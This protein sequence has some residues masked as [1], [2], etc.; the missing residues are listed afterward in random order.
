V[1]RAAAERLRLRRRCANLNEGRQGPVV[2]RDPRDPSD[3]AGSNSVSTDP[4]QT[5]VRAAS[6]GDHEAFGR[7][8]SQYQV[9]VFNLMRA[10]TASD[11]NAEDLAQETFVKA[12]KGIRGFRGDSSFKT[13]LYRIGINVV[14]S[15]RTRRAAWLPVWH[16]RPTDAGSH[17][18]LQVP[19]SPDDPEVSMIR[20]EL[21]DRALA[22]LP[23]DLRVAV[24]LRD[25]AGLEY[26]EIADMTGVPL[27]TVESRIARAR[28]RLRATLAPLIGGP[29][30]DPRPER[31]V[32]SRLPL[33][34]ARGTPVL[35]SSDERPPTTR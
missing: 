20:R 5:L 30:V 22:A 18:E 34:G 2:R 17:R 9:R 25:V 31:P 14:R 16:Q 26:R 32:A 12:F 21:I 29:P 4:D 19:V 33:A 28:Q 23:A 1:A 15:Y 27:G 35:A 24:T 6:E 3:G 7:L 13:W 8:V 11:D 10:L